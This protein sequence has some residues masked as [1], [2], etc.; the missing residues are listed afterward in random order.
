VAVMTG[1]PCVAALDNVLLRASALF[2]FQL[3]AKISSSYHHPFVSRRIPSRFSIACGF[4]IFATTGEDS[5]G[6]DQFSNYGRPPR[7]G[8]NS[9]TIDILEIRI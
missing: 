2:R 1:I 5:L 9:E 6:G 3:Y 4:S 8:R 7:C